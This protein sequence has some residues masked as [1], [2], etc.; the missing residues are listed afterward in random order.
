MTGGREARWFFLTVGSVTLVVLGTGGCATQADVQFVQKELREVRSRVANTRAEVTSLRQQVDELQGQVEE[1]RF[2]VESGSGEKSD[3]MARLEEL[4]LRVSALEQQIG[5]AQPR[6]PSDVEGEG[7]MT[8]P[9]G[10]CERLL[11]A[12]E[13]DKPDG[14]PEQYRKGLKALRNGEY[15]KA[16]QQ[17]REFLRRSPRSDLADD[18]QYWIGEA[19]YQRNDFNRAILELNEV[20]LRYSKG[21]QV[22]AALLRQ[23]DSFQKLGDKLDARLVLQKLVDEHG[24]T[25]EAECAQQKLAELSS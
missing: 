9:E 6:R 21:Q 10:R 23:A 3:A 8:A 2:E 16:I 12:T 4:E 24:N 14:A 5:R 20:L 19:Y 7:A 22:P 25:P 17:F 13:E 18:A 1:L 15:Q 11:V